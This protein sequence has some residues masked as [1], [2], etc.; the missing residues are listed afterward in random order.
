M[1]QG[2]NTF[3]TFNP[4]QQSA[5]SQLL[6]SLQPAGQKSSDYYS[7]LL[8]GS[9]EA[10]QNFE[11]P[12]MRQFHEQTVPGL[13]EQFAG[14]GALSSSGFQQALGQAGAGLSENLA[15]LRSGLQMQAAGQSQSSLQNL[16]GMSTQGLVPKQ[17]GFLKQLLLSLGG[18][19]GQGFGQLAGGGLGSMFGGRGGGSGAGG[20]FG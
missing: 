14:L 4:Q 9:P 12:Y 8:E 15:G 5:F 1:P 7:Q 17:L 18:G 3:S 13:S 20:A 6:A 16:L 19:A 10:F 11:A 2:Y